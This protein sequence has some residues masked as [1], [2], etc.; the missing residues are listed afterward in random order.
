MGKAYEK[1][2]GEQKTFV[3]LFT[4]NLTDTAKIMGIGFKAA[5][6]LYRYAHVKQ[7]IRERFEEGCHPLI[8]DRDERLAFWTSIMRNDSEETGMRLRASELLGKANLDFG[9]RKIVEAQITTTVPKTELDERIAGIKAA[10]DW[11]S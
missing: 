2:T 10:D 5:D 7:A 9:E 8:A 1:L 3:D 4:G 6:T 11:L